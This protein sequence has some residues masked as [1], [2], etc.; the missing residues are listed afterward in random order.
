MH[1][2][3]GPEI[4]FAH[5][6]VFRDRRRQARGPGSDD[7]DVAVDRVAQFCLGRYWRTATPAQ[8]QRYQQLFHQVLANSISDKLGAYE[9]LSLAIGQAEHRFSVMASSRGFVQVTA[10]RCKVP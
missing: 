3:D 2:S 9:G 4:G 8:K 10:E 1:W 5:E 6:R 7:H